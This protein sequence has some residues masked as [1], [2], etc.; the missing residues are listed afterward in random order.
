[1]GFPIT[2][3]SLQVQKVLSNFCRDGE[4][5]IGTGP[6]ATVVPHPC[7]SL[8]LTDYFSQATSLLQT[9]EFVK[10]TNAGK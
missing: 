3:L 1:M 8:Q 6:A 7:L 2:M 10:K 5:W 9:S 4:Y